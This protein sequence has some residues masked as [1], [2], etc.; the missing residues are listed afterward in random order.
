MT[1][2]NNGFDLDRKWQ[3]PKAKRYAFT[4]IALF[5]CLIIIY[6]NSFRCS[7]HLDDF[8]N[9][10]N[11]PNVHL[12]SLSLDHIK[13]AFYDPYYEHNKISRPLSY[14]TFALNY[15]LN[16]NGVFGYHVVNFCIHYLAAAFL[17]LLIYNTL[18]LPMLHRQYQRTAYPIALLSVFLWATHPIQVS[19]VT[20]IVQ[21]MASMASMFYIMAMYFYVRGRLSTVTGKRTVYFSL[22]LGSVFFSL[23]SKE[24]AVMFPVSI[25]LYDLFLI[26]GI[27]RQNIRKNLKIGIILLLTILVISFFYVDISSIAGA[28][29]YRPFTLTERLLT[30]PRVILFYLSLLLYPVS[31]RLTLL[32]DVEFSRSLF[33]PWT[34]LPA[35][36]IIL[37]LILMATWKS[38]KRPLI[39]YCILFFFLNH[40]IEGSIISLELVF[41]HRNYLPSMF[42]FVPIAIWGVYIINYFS[43]KKQLQLTIL[44]LVVF[45]LSAQGHTT[46]LRNITFSNSMTLWTDNIN[47]APNLHRPRHNLAKALLVYGFYDEGILEM[48]KAL[49]A[50]A[51]AR[52]TQKF[53]THYNMGLYYFYQGQYD[54][55]LE[56]YLKI[57]EYLP[58]NP[59]IY[60]RIAI[61]LLAKGDLSRAE[62][63][64]MKALALEPDAPQ[65]RQTLNL[66]LAKKRETDGVPEN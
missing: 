3:S 50:K 34:T 62:K 40:L 10:V 43:Y 63:Y 36:I 65:L 12:K 8:A 59:K 35:I 7:W 61:V 42:V 17:F 39:G 57:F 11:N 30:E 29:K 56:Q 31:S 38:G 45:L 55:S 28:Y 4:F 20:Y 5:V 66:I 15:Y 6:G 9:I 60:Q 27:S 18:Q 53:A 26:Q 32:H 14:L 49:D 2:K 19:A 51:G 58:D 1:N 41:E 47:K 44:F 33:T 24:I 64:V 37:L 25:F 48:K 13:K 52:I 54:K 21:R 46:Y 23:A 22:C 16:D